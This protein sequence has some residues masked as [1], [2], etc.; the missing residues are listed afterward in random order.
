MLKD[1]LEN[2]YR[3]KLTSREKL[4]FYSVQQSIIPAIT[5]RTPDLILDNPMIES[6]N[7]SE[8]NIL[9]SNPE[10]NINLMPYLDI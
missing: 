5:L 10:I 6:F 1:F 9:I 3:I 4:P 2:E 8:A 7:L